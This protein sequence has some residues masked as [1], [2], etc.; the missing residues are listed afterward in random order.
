MKDFL[1]GAELSIRER[2]TLESKCWDLE[3]KLWLRE[4]RTLES[5]CWD[6]EIKLEKK[7][8]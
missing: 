1:V 5:K 8:V 6:L 3:V 7:D 4:R 2:R